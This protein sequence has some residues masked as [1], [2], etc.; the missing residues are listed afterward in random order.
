MRAL[1]SFHR[2]QPA[3]FGFWFRTFLTQRPL[4]WSWDEEDADLLLKWYKHFNWR[5]HL[6]DDIPTVSGVESQRVV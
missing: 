5:R 6:M 4:P 1:Q 2:E 3:N